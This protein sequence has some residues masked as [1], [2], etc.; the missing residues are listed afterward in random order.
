MQ[1]KEWSE[2]AKQVNQRKNVL[3]SVLRMKYHVTPKL[4]LVAQISERLP[5]G[6]PVAILPLVLIPEI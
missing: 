6:G 1:K 2:I 3:W 4:P 5:I